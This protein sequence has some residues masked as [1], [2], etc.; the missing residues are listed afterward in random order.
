MQNTLVDFIWWVPIVIVIHILVFPG[1]Y[2]MFE[3]TFIYQCTKFPKHAKLFSMVSSLINFLSRHTPKIFYRKISSD[4]AP[5]NGKGWAYG[6]MM[7]HL[8]TKTTGVCSVLNVCYQY[9][10]RWYNHVCQL[11]PRNTLQNY[12][13]DHLFSHWIQSCQIPGNDKTVLNHAEA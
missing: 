3:Y 2:V 1:R 6:F 10:N 13:K 9:K 11:F 8:S 7:D 4:V 12:Y 5:E